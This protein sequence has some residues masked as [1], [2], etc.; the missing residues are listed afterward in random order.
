MF[1]NRKLLASLERYAYT[2]EAIVITGFRRVGKTQILKHI[3]ESIRSSN[4]LFIDLESPVNQKLFENQNYELV[5]AS[6]ERL[7]LNFAQK[8]YVFLDEIQNVRQLP[9]VVKYLGDHNDI[10]FYLTGSSSFYLKHWFSESMA[11]RKFVFE[12]FPLD[13]EEFLWFKGV[14]LSTDAGYEQLSGL[15]E[16]FLVYGGFPSVVLAKTKEEKT[17]Q[18]D[19]VLGSYFKLDVQTM[20][21]FRDNQHLKELLFLLSSRVGSR[22][23]MNKLAEN[24]GVSRQTIAKYLTFFEQTY[25]IHMLRPFSVN[26]DVQMRMLPKLY[27]C[28]TGILQ[29]IAQVSRGQLFENK[30]FNQLY[31]A[32]VYSGKQGLM[33]ERIGYY[34]AKSGAEIDFII[35]QKAAYEVKVTGGGFDLQKVGKIAGRLAIADYRVVCLEKIINTADRLIYPYQL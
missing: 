14:R 30:V 32:L 33:G 15:Y 34:Q 2:P 35:D 10:K 9:S 1:I 17:L 31:T 28:D 18:L 3:Y 11:G 19:D 26:K 20:S 12:L 16:E 24:L 22:P 27:F 23:E 8:T 29:R 6:L 13:F 21:N 4:K 25:L 5:K 7:G